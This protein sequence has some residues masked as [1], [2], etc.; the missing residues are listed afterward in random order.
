MSWR[1]ASNC[2]V[3]IRRHLNLIT[4]SSPRV[5][6][7]KIVTVNLHVI[8]PVHYM[9]PAPQVQRLFVDARTLAVPVPCS[10]VGLC[11]L[12]I[13]GV[14]PEERKNDSAIQWFWLPD[15]GH[16]KSTAFI[17]QYSCSRR[18]FITSISVA[19]L[20]SHVLSGKSGPYRSTG[21]TDTN[22]SRKQANSL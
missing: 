7:L 17:Q 1:G 16:R 20:R 21:L 10:K 15:R 3:S 19:L 13:T 9:E 5:R 12:T 2:H 18:L 22:C 4:Q 8:S 14:R 6:T 11:H